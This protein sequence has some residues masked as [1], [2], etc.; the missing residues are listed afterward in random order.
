MVGEAER[1]TSETGAECGEGRR[2]GAF[3]DVKMRHVSEPEVTARSDGL[4][5]HAGNEGSWVSGAST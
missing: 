1:E 4:I 3:L 2:E 5:A